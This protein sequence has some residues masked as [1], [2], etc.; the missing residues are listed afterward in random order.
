[1]NL[2]HGFN[3]LFH[4][5]FQA[6]T[7]KT[8][9]MLGVSDSIMDDKVKDE[10]LYPEDA[11]YIRVDGDFDGH[12]EKY[13]EEGSSPN[14]SASANGRVSATMRYKCSVC[15]KQGYD[16]SKMKRHIKIHGRDTELIDLGGTITRPLACNVCKKNFTDKSAFHQHKKTST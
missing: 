13:D 1:M 10:N 3:L 5:F 11:T 6:K 12:S 15:H 14:S 9:I 8:A 4:Y 16:R 2:V 7:S